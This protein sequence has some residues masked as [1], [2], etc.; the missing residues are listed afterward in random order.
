MIKLTGVSKSYGMGKVVQAVD[1]V[2]LQIGPAVPV[3]SAS[4]DYVCCP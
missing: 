2:S 1:N 3:I 4:A